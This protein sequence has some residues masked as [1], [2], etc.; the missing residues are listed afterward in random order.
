LHARRKGRSLSLARTALIDFNRGEARV[1][2]RQAERLRVGGIEL[3]TSI[4][5]VHGLC[6]KRR[7]STRN[8]RV[9]ADMDT[10]DVVECVW[11]IATRNSRARLHVARA[12]VANQ[13]CNLM[14][15]CVELGHG[16]G[17]IVEGA[18]DLAKGVLVALAHKARP[19]NG[20]AVLQ[21]LHVH[22]IDVVLAWHGLGVTVIHLDQPAVC[23]F[24]HLD[25]RLAAAAAA[26]TTT[27]TAMSLCSRSH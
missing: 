5:G 27:A 8:R 13:A 1:A 26:T 22:A 7:C 24:C 6:I 19:A 2:A 17:R 16:T 9:E 23:A 14:S 21:A 4:V 3:H 20:V 11:I 12:P 25:P 10:F 18:R 15:L